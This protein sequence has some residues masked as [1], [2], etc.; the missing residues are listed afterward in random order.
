MQTGLRYTSIATE[1]DLDIVD[2]WVLYEK[3][4]WSKNGH[5]VG[6]SKAYLDTLISKSRTSRRK[7]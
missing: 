1:S 7:K 6:K 2:M 4:Y 3:T 5:F